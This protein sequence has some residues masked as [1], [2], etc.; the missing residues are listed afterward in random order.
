M[1]MENVN[2]P[3][4]GVSTPELPGPFGKFCGNCEPAAR[5]GCRILD[6]GFK[7]AAPPAIPT[8][9]YPELDEISKDLAYAV[10]MEINKRT[11]AVTSKM[12]YKAQYVLEE[13][14]KLLR[15]KV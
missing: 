8:S 10:S 7:P 14:I 4:C 2:C 9:K 11:A 15:E 5:A 13:L 3:R 6:H 1:T 12:P